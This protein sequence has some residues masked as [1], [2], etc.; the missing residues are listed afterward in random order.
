VFLKHT[1]Q[2]GEDVEIT[3]QLT[4]QERKEWE[5]VFKQADERKRF[6]KKDEEEVTFVKEL[7]QLMYVPAVWADG[8][9]PNK[10]DKEEEDE[11]EEDNKE[12]KAKEEPQPL[13]EA[14]FM[15]VRYSPATSVRKKVGH[16]NPEWVQH[17]FKGIYINLIML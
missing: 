2:L 10:E 8:D 13:F 3:N 1:K 12:K 9:V 6:S 17:F 11:E 5:D 14:H 15:G 7:M 16:L 4:D